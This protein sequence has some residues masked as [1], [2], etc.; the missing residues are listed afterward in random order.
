M[1][2]STPIG[3]TPNG[4]FELFFKSIIT[5][6][7][8]NVGAYTWETAAEQLELAVASDPNAT[9]ANF[10]NAIY[11]LGFAY[12]NLGDSA[13]A[14]RVF[15]DLLERY[16][17]QESVIRPYISSGSSAGAAAT[18]GENG[19]GAASMSQDNS[20]SDTSGQD[21][22]TIYGD[23]QNSLGYDPADVA[24]TDP[25]TGLHYDMYGNLLG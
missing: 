14:D 13:N 19:Q 21:A 18:A 2:A 15:T 4:S 8:S 16:P 25:N 10:F 24:W 7:L 3:V 12:F 1:D 22:I 23:D 20:W 5:S 6:R 17:G 11:Y 9:E